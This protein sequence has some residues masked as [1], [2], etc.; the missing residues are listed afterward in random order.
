M[1]F[2]IGNLKFKIREKRRDTPDIIPKD[3]SPKFLWF[4][5]E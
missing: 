1:L 3:K 5:I 2:E 4:I